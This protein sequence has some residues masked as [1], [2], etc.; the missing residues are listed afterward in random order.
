MRPVPDPLVSLPGM[1][2]LLQDPAR[3]QF[4]VREVLAAFMAMGGVR[5]ESNVLI[6][7]D[8]R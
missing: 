3:A 5:I 8:G 7:A 1:R 4:L 6:T 2:R